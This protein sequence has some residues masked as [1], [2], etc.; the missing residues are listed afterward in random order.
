M[1]TIN[2]NATITIPDNVEVTIKTRNV[3]VKGPRGSL[4]RSFKHLQLDVR[5]LDA[6]T[7]SVDAWHASKKVRFA[8][9]AGHG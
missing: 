3:T 1:R 8:C 2:S 5:K 4:N 9:R 6:K 7:I